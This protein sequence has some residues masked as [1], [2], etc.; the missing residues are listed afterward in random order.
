MADW[1]SVYESQ[2]ADGTLDLGSYEHKK[3]EAS[4]RILPKTTPWE[5]AVSISLVPIFPWQNSQFTS[6]PSINCV[7]LAQFSHPENALTSK[8][9]LPLQRRPM[10]WRS[11]QEGWLRF[12]K[13]E[14]YQK[15]GRTPPSPPHPFPT[16]LAPHVC[17]SPCWQEWFPSSS[18]EH[19]IRFLHLGFRSP[20]T[21]NSF[22]IIQL[23]MEAGGV[24]S[25]Q[26]T[27]AF[28]LLYPSN[29]PGH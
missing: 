20:L 10:F 13:E 22:V 18:L 16:H 28:Q 3:H 24:T 25:T 1:Q 6:P 2:F 11:G 15:Y 19:S 4:K 5:L 27:E 7:W 21:N 9:A 29:P 14:D 17:P 26:G 12:L 8:W 23:G